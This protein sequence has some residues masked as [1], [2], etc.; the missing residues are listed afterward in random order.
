MKLFIDTANISEI[1][2]AASWGIISGV[3]TNPSLAAKEGR[4]FREVIEEICQLV[5]GP[6]SAEALSSKA[7]QI[8]PEARGLATINKNIVVKIPITAE[9]LTATKI[10]SAEGIKINMTLVFSVNQALMAAAAGAAF[11]SPFLG[12]LDDIGEDGLALL[13]DIINVYNNYNIETAV[14]AASIRHPQHV[15]QAALIGTDVATVPFEVLKKM[16]HHPLT[17]KGIGQFLADWEKLQ[18]TVGRVKLTVDR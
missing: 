5:D 9:G 4:D 7:E 15:T 6:I 11:A 13:S 12:R 10:L 3:T 8:V 14:I 1:R 16:I 17:E 18:S 2:E